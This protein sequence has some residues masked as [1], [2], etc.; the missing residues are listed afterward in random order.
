MARMTADSHLLCKWG[1]R[2]RL[3]ESANEEEGSTLFMLVFFSR[4]D[5]YIRLAPLF[6]WLFTHWRCWLSD[7]VG[8]GAHWCHLNNLSERPFM[9]KWNSRTAVRRLFFSPGLNF[10]Y[11]LNLN[12]W[13]K[14]NKINILYFANRLSWWHLNMFTTCDVQHLYLYIICIL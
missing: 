12:S 1:P 10:S 4:S 14:I 8:F 7:S 5:F 13:S 2:T 9:L 11:H 6:Y 3:M